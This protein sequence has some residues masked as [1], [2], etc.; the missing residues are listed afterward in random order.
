LQAERTALEARIVRG[1][2]AVDDLVGRLE[3]G[4]RKFKRRWDD[5]LRLEE[6]TRARYALLASG[7][8]V[9]RALAAVTESGNVKLALGPRQDY[10]KALQAMTADQAKIQALLSAPR[11]RVELKGMSRLAGLAGA[12]EAIQRELGIALGRLQTVEH[13]AESRERMLADQAAR[14]HDA[15]AG[16]GR[17]PAP[18]PKGRTA[19]RPD[20][21]KSRTEKLRADLAQSRKTTR[22]ALQQVASAREDFV[23]GVAA[24]RAELDVA[25]SRPEDLADASRTRH[26]FLMPSPGEKVP[27]MPTVEQVAARLRE[28]ERLIREE[29]VQVDADK[30]ILWVDASLN[31]KP[32]SSMV[33]DLDAEEVRLPARVAAEVGARLDDGDP[34]A[35]VT[36]IDGRTIP[37]R[38]ARLATVQ[39]GPVT[40]SDVE[41]VVL[42][43]GYS[44]APALLGRSFLRHFATRLDPGSGT[45]KLTQVSVKPIG[46]A[47]KPATTRPATS[48]P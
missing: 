31:G 46:R 14:E 27:K 10:A 28:F 35:Q 9:K 39:V 8:D 24:L 45:L 2:M 43:E 1:Q 44:E 48:T 19:P 13:D 11:S 36:T 22:D 33:I 23:R 34:T 30:A 41:C 15:A 37:A 3:E 38:R 16:P 42:P 7:S 21:A 5:A 6:E 47:G 20:D 40:A 17:G 32:G 25:A 4:L 12:V 18:A 29:T 26:E